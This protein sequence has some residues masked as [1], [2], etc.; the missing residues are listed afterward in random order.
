MQSIYRVKIAMGGW[1]LVFLSLMGLSSCVPAATEIPIVLPVSPSPT[2]TSLPVAEAEASATVSPVLTPTPLPPDFWTSLPVVPETIS[3][4]TRQIY[5]TGLQMGNNPRVF[6]RIGDCA[7]AAP[8]FLVGFDS[9]YHLGEY[10]YLQP[11]IEYFQG[12]FQRPS[13]AARA[14]LNTAGVLSSL[15]NGEQCYPD[16]SLLEC[17]YRLDQ[18]AF[19]FI[20]LG[21]NDAYYVRRDPAS[22]E[23]NMR[24]ILDKT[25]ARGIVPILATK[26]DNAEGN[27]AINATIA[28]LALEYEIPLWNFWLAVQPLPDHGMRDPEHLTSVSFVNFTDFTIPDSLEYGMQ[29]RNLTALQVLD[30]LRRELA[31]STPSSST[32]LP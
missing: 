24:I 7:S 18:P 31:E 8:G 9:N 20:S 19:A 4:R 30:L 1:L 13:L 2:M 21:S 14:G 16:E 15:W 5:L 27:Q 6:S 17:Q 28:R 11:T 32:D 3:D 25:I 26:A 10:D 23:R 22:F 12:S 29:V